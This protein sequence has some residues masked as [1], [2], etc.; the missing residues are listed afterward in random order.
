MTGKRSSPYFSARFGQ[1]GG[2]MWAW[3]SILSTESYKPLGNAGY[4]ADDVARLL[5]IRGTYPRGAMRAQ[6]Y[7]IAARPGATQ[8]TRAL[9][10]P[11]EGRAS[12]RRRATCTRAPNPGAEPC[13]AHGIQ[14]PSGGHDAVDRYNA[15][16]AASP[17]RGVLAGGARGRR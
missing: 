6:V 2:R 3:V 14:S 17:A 10:R 13:A 9:S 7:A 4:K 11:R 15:P 16:D 12:C 5:A 8:R 1:D